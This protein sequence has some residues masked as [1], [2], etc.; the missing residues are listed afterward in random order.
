[1]SGDLGTCAACGS[2]L[3]PADFQLPACRYCGAAF[4]HHQEAA[5]KVAELH[6][7]MGMM[8]APSPP[9][10]FVDPAHAVVV[11]GMVP[12]QHASAPY[13]A[14]PPGALPVPPGGFPSPGAYPSPPAVFPVAPAYPRAA[15]HVWIYVL[16]AALV[17]VV[18]LVVLGA[19][20]FMFVAV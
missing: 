16:I 14:L 9:G 20:A 5:A 12:I 18:M 1:M 19:A 10:V 6:A 11:P 4:R 8:R 13:A 7:V 3:T 17:G 2:H 15:S